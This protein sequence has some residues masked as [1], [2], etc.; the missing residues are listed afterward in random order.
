M[1]GRLASMRLTTWPTIGV[2][3]MPV[4]SVVFWS[5]TTRVCAM[6]AAGFVVG[7]AAVDD[8]AGPDDRSTTNAP[9]VA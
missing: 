3:R 1:S 4:V 8:P 6:R 2:G 7:H 5:A 9:G